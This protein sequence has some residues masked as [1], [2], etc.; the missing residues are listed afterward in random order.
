MSATQKLL[1]GLSDLGMEKMQDYLDHYSEL[2]NKG[3]KSFTEALEELVDIEKNN[4]QMRRDAI[5]LHI[6]N[7]PFIKTLDDFNFDFQPSLNKKELLELG[8]LGF[9]ENKENVVFVGSSGVGKTHLAT[10]LGI[11]CTK[12]RFQ[13]YFITFENLVMQL[14]KAHLENRLESR[15]KFFAKYKVLIIDEIGYMPID[16]DTANIFFQL[17]ARRYEKNSTIITTNMPF[18]KWGEFFGSPTLANAVLDRLLHHSEIISIKGPSYR[19]KDIR[20]LIEPQ[21]A[22]E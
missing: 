18:S 4:K 1:N 9:V 13:T 11:A 21:A 10:A 16:H 20:A 3:E 6:A 12:A 7:Y 17:I 2:V 5:N 19:T 14:K 15:L 22:E 8:S